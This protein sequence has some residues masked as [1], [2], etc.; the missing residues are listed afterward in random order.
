MSAMVRPP[1]FYPYIV[2]ELGYGKI[3]ASVHEAVPK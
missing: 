2:L 3:S 1:R